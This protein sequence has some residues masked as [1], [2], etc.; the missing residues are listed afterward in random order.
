[1]CLIVNFLF[2]YKQIYKFVT[3]KKSL[4]LALKKNLSISHAKDKHEG[5]DSDTCIL[6]NISKKK[7]K[8]KTVKHTN[9]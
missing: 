6:T 4:T 5:F 7:K 9:E 3:K 2:F 1:M 8:I